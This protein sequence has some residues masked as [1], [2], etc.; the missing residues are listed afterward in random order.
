MI[1][2]T[3]FYFGS[4]KKLTGAFGQLFS[5]IKIQRFNEDGSIDKTISVP[6]R[7]SP[8]QKWLSA[9]NERDLDNKVRIRESLPRMGFEITGI[10]Y[11]STRQLNPL[12][13]NNKFK[14]NDIEKFLKQLIPVPYDISY[15]LNIKVK[16]ADDG[17]QILEQILPF[18]CP[19]YNIRIEDIPQLGITRDVRLLFTGNIST[20]DNY[21]GSYTE[22][23]EITH[24]LSFVMKGYIYPH[25]K[26]SGIIREAIAKIYGNTVPQGDREVLEA[27]PVP[28]T[29]NF[30]NEEWTA[31]VTKRLEQ[32]E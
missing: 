18:F 26:D 24:E 4:I 14:D 17:L 2:E 28:L 22:N 16:N 20:S 12:R 8:G 19:S 13:N 3:P 31:K 10:Q 30:G 27:R 9:R 5:N 11:D 23:R 25:I 15:S 29:A 21:E 6:I 1:T 32:D 7:Y